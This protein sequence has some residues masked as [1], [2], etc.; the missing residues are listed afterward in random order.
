MTKRIHL[1]NMNTGEKEMA[2]GT[3]SL[4]QRIRTIIMRIFNFFNFNFLKYVFKYK[5]IIIQLWSRC[6]FLSAYSYS[7]SSTWSLLLEGTN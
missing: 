4:Y 7:G 6:Y 3:K 2:N 5:Y 1:I